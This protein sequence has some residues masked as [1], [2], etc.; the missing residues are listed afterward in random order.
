M[1]FTFPWH[2]STKSTQEHPAVGAFVPS[3]QVFAK[4]CVRPV[5]RRVVDTCPGSGGHEAKGLELEKTGI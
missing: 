3:L 2:L 4:K 5:W 1:V